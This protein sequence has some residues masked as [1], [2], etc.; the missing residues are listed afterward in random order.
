MAGEIDEH[1]G[2][3]IRERRKE[4]GLTQA[5]LGGRVGLAHQTIH[6]F[7]CGAHRVCAEHH[8]RLSLALG[9]PVGYFFDGL[10]PATPRK[11]GVAPSA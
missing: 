4:A 5:E 10:D 7:E 9:V 8:W 3:R 2:R 6:K 11:G 1:V